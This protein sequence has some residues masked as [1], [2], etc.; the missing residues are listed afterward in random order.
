MGNAFAVAEATVR[1]TFEV[2][3]AFRKTYCCY[4]RCCTDQEFAAV[5]HLFT[6]QQVFSPVPAPS[7]QPETM[8]RVGPVARFLVVGL[9]NHGMEKT[10]HS[11]GM[12]VVSRMASKFE[13]K[14]EMDKNCKGY[15]AHA[16]SIR[17]KFLL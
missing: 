10:R 4:I 13:K 2:C 7:F 17:C 12:Q 3:V 15:V 8:A 5:I 9:G 1:S 14:L 16:H 11:I 6:C